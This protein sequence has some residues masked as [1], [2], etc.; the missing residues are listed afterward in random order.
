M[1]VMAAGFVAM[2]AQEMI[3]ESLSE[4]CG[5]QNCLILQRSDDWYDFC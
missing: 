4:E 2:P 3:D 1:T 5:N